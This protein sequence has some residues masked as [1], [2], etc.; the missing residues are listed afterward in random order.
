[1]ESKI[2]EIEPVANSINEHLK[3][4]GNI[5]EIVDKLQSIPKPIVV[6]FNNVLANNRYPLTVNPAAKEFIDK[7]SSIGNVIIATTASGWDI[8]HD[9]LENNGLWKEEMIL[10][11]GGSL[12]NATVPTSSL[13]PIITELVTKQIDLIKK[14]GKEVQI[15]DFHSA[16]AGKKI[17]H[18]FGKSFEIPIIDDN[19][20]A[21]NDNPEMFGIWV[22]LWD[23]ETPNKEDYED[24]KR[25]SLG[26]AAKIVEDYYKQIT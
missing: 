9:F 1:M 14:A 23:P 17:S 13:D 20:R 4:G 2:Y 26:E 25:Y 5:L 6:D 22:E 7:L 8:V 12:E 21:V 11:N 15:R 16:V 19:Y 10:I 18:L 3:R 24:Q